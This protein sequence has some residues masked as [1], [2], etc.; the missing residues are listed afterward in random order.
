MKLFSVNQLCTSSTA[1]VQLWS[2]S[3]DGKVYV[4]DADSEGEL[5]N[6]RA[7]THQSLRSG[8]RCLAHNASCTGAGG[9]KT[10]SV[11]FA[12]AED[13]KVAIWDAVEETFLVSAS[14]HSNIVSAL[15]A[16]GGMVRFSV[17]IS[18]GMLE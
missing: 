10:I 2:G 8:V 6:V 12:G 9:S 13:G 16:M 1:G 11:V 18:Y 15:C 5:Q 4:Y 14:I 7:L 3:M 17:H